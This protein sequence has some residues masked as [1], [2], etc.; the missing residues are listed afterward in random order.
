MLR[1]ARQDKR[2]AT[3]NQVFVDFLLMIEMFYRQYRCLCW[4][5]QF[6]SLIKELAFVLVLRLKLIDLEIIFIISLN[7]ASRCCCC[8]SLTKSKIFK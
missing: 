8:V 1:H 7:D 6:P 2:F 4:M 3:V 5:C